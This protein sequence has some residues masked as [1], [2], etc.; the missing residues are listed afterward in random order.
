MTKTVFWKAAAVCLIAAVTSCY[1]A[2]STQSVIQESTLKTYLDYLASASLEGRKVLEP[3]SKTAAHFIAENFLRAGLEPGAP[4]QRFYQTVPVETFRFLGDQTWMTD[5]AGDTLRADR[6]FWLF[7]RK[8]VEPVSGVVYFCGYGIQ[9]PQAGYD[10]YKNVDV[11]GKFVIAF[12]G[13]PE[14]KDT[15]NL[16]GKGRSTRYAMIPVKVGI[17]S[18]LGAVGLILTTPTSQRSNV[19]QRVVAQKQADW[20]PDIIQS[21]GD[22]EFPVIY[23]DPDQASAVFAGKAN[24]NLQQYTDELNSNLKGASIPVPGVELRFNPSFSETVDTSTVNVIGILEGKSGTNGEAIVI[25]AHYDHLGTENGKIYYGADDNASGVSALLTLAKAL[26]TKQMQLDRTIIFISFG[27][28]EE[29][30]I[31]SRYYVEHPIVPLDKTVAMLNMD[32]IGREGSDSYR[33]MLRPPQTDKE[34]NLL[35]TF[36]SANYPDLKKLILDLPNPGDLW[37]RPDPLTGSFDFGDHAPFL[38]HGV[39]VMFFFSGYNADDNTAGDTVDKIV[40]P[41]LTRITAL[42][43]DAIVKLSNN[44]TQLKEEAVKTPS[45]SPMY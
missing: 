35:F 27:A 4:N 25:G 3:G 29:G 12:L 19:W 13:E 23:L 30:L 40:F 10:D 20:Q 42:I 45:S 7:P 18:K 24:L 9:A 17:A 33:N 34:R 38:H 16:F 32:C 14:T 6:D 31:G 44:S 11:S 15:T 1:A 2:D 36:Y 22:K 37:L 41:K 8:R 39:P 26:G 5:S 43:Y 21:V 28:E